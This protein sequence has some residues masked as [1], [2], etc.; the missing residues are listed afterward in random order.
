ML[1]IPGIVFTSCRKDLTLGQINWR[2]AYLMPARTRARRYH[3]IQTHSVYAWFSKS[4]RSCFRQMRHD[5]SLRLGG[6][7]L[8]LLFFFYFLYV[9]HRTIRKTCYLILRV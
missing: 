6:I 7:V 2:V 4:N 8:L 3:F 1:V 9:R 5:N